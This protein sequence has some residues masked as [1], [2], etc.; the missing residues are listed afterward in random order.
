MGDGPADERTRI[1]EGVDAGDVR[2]RIQPF[3]GPF[4]CATRTMVAGVLAGVQQQEPSSCH[5]LRGLVFH[6]EDPLDALGC[7]AKP[8][9]WLNQRKADIALSVFPEAAAR[10][11]DHAGL[12]HQEGRKF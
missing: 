1:A 12:V 8:R 10:G 6:L 5:C 3:D 9:G 7:L 2:E 11:D 4:Q